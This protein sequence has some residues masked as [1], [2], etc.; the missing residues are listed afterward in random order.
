MSERARRFVVQ[1]P[2]VTLPDHLGNH[3]ALIFLSA[4]PQGADEN[5]VLATCMD[6]NGR[7]HGN[8]PFSMQ[9][10]RYAAEPRNRVTLIEGSDAGLSGPLSG[11]VGMDGKPLA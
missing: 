1:F 5:L 11:M 2:C 9:A 7:M 6:I 10:I 4:K 3:R 8:V